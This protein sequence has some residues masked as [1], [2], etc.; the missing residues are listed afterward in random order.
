MPKSR[1]AELDSNQ[2]VST[3]MNGQEAGEGMFARGVGFEEGEARRETMFGTLKEAVGRRSTHG[4]DVLARKVKGRQSLGG[5]GGEGNMEKGGHE[6]VENVEITRSR[7]LW[8][9][10]T[11]AMTF[12]APS[13]LLRWCGRMQRPDV[14]MA[15]REKVAI[16]AI[17]LFLW[18]VLLFVIIG[19]GLILCPKENVWTMDDVTNIN[20]PKKSYMS[21]RGDV[22]DITDFIKQTGHGT[23]RNRARTDQLSMF[24]GFDTNTSFPITAREACPDLVSAARD[25]NYLIQYPVSG[26]SSNVDPQAGVYFKHTRQTDPTSK[27]L[28]DRGFYWKYFQPA[29]EKF[30]KG[31]VVWKMD[32]LNTMYK[33]Q[34]MQ[35]LVVNKEVFYM[36]P[37]IDAI[38]YAGNTNKTYNFLDSR[39]EAL[40]NRGGYGTADISED[41]RGLN[42]DAPTM[43][44][45]YDCMK[46]LF[47][48]GKV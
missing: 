38:Q 6:H 25:P 28:S 4:D 29:M 9:Y 31:G 15:W 41:W 21:S 11:W 3:N 23:A 34:S 13:P 19:L 42:W 22:Y 33:D 47:Y 27:E 43:Q 32:W 35:W 7:K 18:F 17:V 37:Y 5:T 1:Y 8:V 44:T 48:V 20:T 16:C 14:R 12:W 39:F 45:N 40:L 30:K 46:R 24:A 10:F 36:Q 2:S 26:A